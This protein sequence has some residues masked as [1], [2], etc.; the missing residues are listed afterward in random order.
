MH[1]GYRSGFRS[2]LTAENRPP[3]STSIA[4]T[5]DLSRGNAIGASGSDELNWREQKL[6]L[7][8]LPRLRDRKKRRLLLFFYLFFLVPGSR[9][10]ASRACCGFALR[11]GQMFTSYDAVLPLELLKAAL[12]YGLKIM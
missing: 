5:E 12:P 8:A 9:V 2:G 7:G 3:D 10:A 11:S 4:P 1:I 6:D